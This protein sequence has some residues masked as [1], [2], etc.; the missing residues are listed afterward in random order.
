LLG[1]AGSGTGYEVADDNEEVRA[2]V[3]RTSIGFR[4]SGGQPSHGGTTR[5]LG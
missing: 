3:I 1:N 2:R 5:G 4:R